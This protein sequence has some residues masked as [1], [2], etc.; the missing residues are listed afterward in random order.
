MAPCS[1]A[2]MAYWSYAVTK[3]R[4][5]CPASACAALMPS[6]SGMLMSRKTMSGSRLCTIAIASRPLPA[7]P[8]IIS[9]GHASFSRPTIC[10]RI[11]R[12]SST[13]TAV[14]AGLACMI[15]V[16]SGAGGTDLVGHLD[17]GAGAAR[18][19][20]A[21]DQLC[22]SFVQGLQTLADIGEPHAL[23]ALG[24]EAD[25]VVEHLHGELAVDDLSAD[26]HPSAF[27]PGLE[28]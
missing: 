28:A 9:S 25:A 14:G 5:A 11:R 18:R 10:S 20:H 1:K 6:I 24:H 15:D 17:G 3:T 7:S 21:D 13:T 26:L 22:T 12:S 23:V 4:C 8:T 27:S 16:R 19:R 2:R